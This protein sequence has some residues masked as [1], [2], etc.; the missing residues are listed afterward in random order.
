MNVKDPI[1]IPVLPAVGLSAATGGAFALGTA[2]LL[3][4]ATATGLTCVFAALTGVDCPFCGLTH[5][6]AAL[7]AGDPAAALAAHPLAPLA[8]ALAIAVPVVLLRRRGC[9]SRRPSSGGSS[10]SCSSSGWRG[11]CERPLPAAAERFAVRRAAGVPSERAAE[12]GGRR[13][14]GPRARHPASCSAA[15]RSGGVVAGRSAEREVDTGGGQIGGRGLATAGKILGMI[16]TAFL[17][18]LVRVPRPRDRVRLV[19]RRAALIMRASR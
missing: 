19:D 14:R 8:V 9:R 7:G 12:D 1:R 4:G 18:V 2:G 11:S 3:G 15:V 16:G 17:V 13:G 10:P 5:G 6:V